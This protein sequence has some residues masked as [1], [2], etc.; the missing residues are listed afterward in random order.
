MTQMWSGFITNW[1]HLGAIFSHQSSIAPQLIMRITTLFGRLDIRLFALTGFC[2]N[3]GNTTHI[4]LWKRFLG[5][6]GLSPRRNRGLEGNNRLRRSGIHQQL[7]QHRL[8]P[9]GLF[10][11]WVCRLR[12]GALGALN[13]THRSQRQL[14]WL[15]DL[16]KG[17]RFL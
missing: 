6:C 1:I 16:K 15:S 3:R 12:R 11:G 4:F 14:K 10:S 2:S 9:P 13:A 5:G 8:C 7:F 17:R